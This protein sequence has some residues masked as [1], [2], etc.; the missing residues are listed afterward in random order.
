MDD[1]GS[2]LYIII[3][4]IVF[5]V[6]IFAGGNKEKKGRRPVQPRPQNQ[7][8]QGGG[9]Q[10]KTFEELLREFSQQQDPQP[11]R[12]LEPEP[13]YQ[14][15]E[16]EPFSY[17]TAVNDYDDEEA[18][19]RYERSIKMAQ[20]S[21]SIDDLE[22]AMGKIKAGRMQPYKLKKTGSVQLEPIKRKLQNP[23][24][25]REAIIFKEIIDRKYT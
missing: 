15:R 3:G 20:S 4:I 23:K 1:I 21:H 13:Q 18:I 25:L 7:Q 8:P 14:Q 22:S 10:P 24:T 12:R 16:E 9:Q 6:R 17:E 19:A 2:Y 5:L 11:E